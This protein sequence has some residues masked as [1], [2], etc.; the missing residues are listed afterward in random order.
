MRGVS[1]SRVAAALVV[2]L[3]LAGCTTL[4]ER[5]CKSADWEAIGRDDGARGATPSK[6]ARHRETCALYGVKPEEQA[7]QAGY[8]QGLV[9][10]CTPAGGYVAGRDG[11]GDHRL[12]AGRPQEPAFLEALRHGQE[13]GVLL[14][15]VRALRRALRDTE[16]A[17]LAG[18][19]GATEEA[20][21]NMQVVELRA[22]LAAKLWELGRL[23]GEYAVKFGA[24]PLEPSEPR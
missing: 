3:A 20:Q 16:M 9:S 4:S 22:A 19:R 6:L 13:V 24:K 12:C 17:A 10:Y 23:D 7:W 5:E 21:L 1:A 14:R 8:A 15:E 2:A 18:N 11:E